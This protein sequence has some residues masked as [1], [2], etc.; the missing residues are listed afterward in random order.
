[1]VSGAV[2]T[3]VSLFVFFIYNDQSKITERCKKC[4]PGAYHDLDLP[5]LCPL[6]LIVSFSCG[7]SG[8]QYGNFFSKP[9][10]KSSYCLIGKC[11]LRD[12]YDHLSALF[13]HFLDEFH[14][15]LGLAA[16]GNSTKEYRSGVR[17]FP[18]L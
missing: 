13:Y 5:K 6:E 2:F 9:S 11:D 17:L 7:K 4:R 8:I 15:Y 16:S 1:M 10:I 12:Q 3:F 14:V 18:F